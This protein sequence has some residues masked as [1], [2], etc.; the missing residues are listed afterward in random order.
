MSHFL[1]LESRIKFTY[2]IS[3]LL[4]ECGK[5]IVVNSLLPLAF[6]LAALDCLVDVDIEA[7]DLHSQALALLLKLPNLILHVVLALL[8]H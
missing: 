6:L 2:I 5:L 8:S 7:L 3:V 1:T 4:L